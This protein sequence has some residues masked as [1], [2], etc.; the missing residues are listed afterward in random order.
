MR[1]SFFFKIRGAVLQYAVLVA[2][3]VFFLISSFILLTHTQNLFRNQSRSILRDIDAVN[4]QFMNLDDKVANTL[5]GITIDSLEVISGYQGAFQKIQIRDKKSYSK[6]ALLGTPTPEQRV[7]LYLAD[8]NQPLVL[9]GDTKIQGKVYLPSAGVKAGSISGT[10]FTGTTLVDQPIAYSSNTLPRLHENFKTYLSGIQSGIPDGDGLVELKGTVK[11][12]F[13]NAEQVIYSRERLLLVEELVGNI[14][15]HSGTEIVLGKYA[16]LTDVTVVAP[17]I[18]IENGFRGRIHAIAEDSIIVGENVHLRYPSSLVL[19]EIDRSGIPAPRAI[20]VSENSTVEGAVV[21]LQDREPEKKQ[22]NVHISE[23]ATVRGDIYCQG[24][25]ELK[26]RVEGTVYSQ[27]LLTRTSGGVYINHIMGG[28]I[29]GDRKGDS[30][31]GL[32]L[33][34]G[35]KGIAQWLY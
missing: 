10:Y 2:V 9:V 33:Q 16:T 20:T 3:L 11:N 21:F 34:N 12:S 7:A 25:I 26:G 23:R 5:G 19:S 31:C 14:R 15:I 17:T 35:K 1:K 4:G 6:I 29:L 27:Q 24:F 8:N 32:P 18:R 30:F 22:A 13:Y 28:T